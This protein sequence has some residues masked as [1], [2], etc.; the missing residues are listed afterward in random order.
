[1][2]VDTDKDTKVQMEPE[3]EYNAHCSRCPYV[4]PVLEVGLAVWLMEMHTTENHP[5]AAPPISPSCTS[6]PGTPTDC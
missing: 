2:E 1:M 4:T 3:L 5:L 6:L